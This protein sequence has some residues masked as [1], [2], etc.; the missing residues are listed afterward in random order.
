MNKF[1]AFVKNPDVHNF[2]KE[3]AVSVAIA[4]AIKVVVT[5]AMSRSRIKAIW[6]FRSYS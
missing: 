4:I 3:V 5:V 2:V 6:F 1:T